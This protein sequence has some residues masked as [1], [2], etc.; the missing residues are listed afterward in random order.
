MRASKHFPIN[1]PAAAAA[2][3]VIVA[4]GLYFIVFIRSQPM[5]LLGS[6]ILRPIAAT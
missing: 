6:K 4:L 2:A 3:S 1:P 5:P